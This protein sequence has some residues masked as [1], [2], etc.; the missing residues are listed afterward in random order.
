MPIRRLHVL[1]VLPLV[2]S[3]CATDSG[4]SRVDRQVERLILET[5]TDLGEDA[6]RPEVPIDRE[7]GDANHRTRYRQRPPTTNPGAA[8]LIFE[9]RVEAEEVVARLAEWVPGQEPPA[10]AVY[11]DLPGALAYA[12][13][14]A[15]EHR[16]AREEYV[17]AALRLLVE[18]HLWGPR[19]FNEVSAEIVSS[20][21]DGFFDTSFQIVNELQVTQRLPYGGEIA[22]GALAFGAADLHSRVQDGTTQAAE[23]IFSGTVPLLRGAGDIAREDRITAERGLV[24]AARD[25]ERFRREFLVSIAEDFLNLVVRVQAIDNAQ[26]QVESLVWLERRSEAFVETG[27]ETPIDLALAQR[28]TLFARDALNNQIE[29]YRLALERFKVRIGMDPLQP[30]VIVRSDPGLAVPEV[31]LDEAVARALM[32]RLDLQTSRDEVDDARR[33][34][35]VARNLLLP[36]LDLFGSASVPTDPRRRRGGV[37]LRPGFGEFVGGVTFGLPLDREIERVNVRQAQITLERLIREYDRLRDSLVVET[38]SAVRDIDRAMFSLSIQERN[39][40]IA[41]RA[42]EAIRADPDRATPRDRTEAVDALLRAQGDLDTAR[43]D[44]QVAIL[45]YLLSSGQLRVAPDGTI[46]PLTGMELAQP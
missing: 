3:G 12:N 37:S 40:R 29:A 23:L 32:Y 13:R 24:Y 43:R 6:V 34:V 41:E 7:V 19:F 35:S 1:L 18:R 11:L 22:I 20:G 42:L 36:D 2:I 5:S 38:R 39:V 33:G 10:D 17:L 25:Y 15:R 21:D 46:L 31:T 44:L 4:L 45:R 26:R 27:R 28:S 9:P 16:F 8:D 14:Y 30:V